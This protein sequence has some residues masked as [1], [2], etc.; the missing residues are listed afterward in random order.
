LCPAG[1]RGW[2]TE[3]QGCSRA[4]GKYLGAHQQGWAVGVALTLTVARCLDSR[5]C[6]VTPARCVPRMPS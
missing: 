4:G 5:Q 6:R 3:G 2:E 1:A